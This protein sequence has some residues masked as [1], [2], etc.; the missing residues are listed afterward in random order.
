MP[1]SSDAGGRP[2]VVVADDSAL[3]RRVLADVL[4]GG[5]RDNGEFRVVATA[6]DGLDAIRK[7]HQHKP[8]VVT[9][10]L[11]MPQLD[12]L[13]AIGY[14]MSEA[15]RPIVVVSAHAGP[16][17]Q[18]AIRA[19]ELGAVEIVAKPPPEVF[20]QPSAAPE[21]LAPQLIAA[22]PRVVA[23]AAYAAPGVF[24][25]QVGSAAAG[26]VIALDQSAPLW[27]VRPTADPLFRSIAEVYAARAVGV[28]LTGL[29]RDGASG[30]R[31]MRDAGATRLA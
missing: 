2:T 17:T 6:R 20:G 22:V 28:V 19:L 12:G 13:G 10:D 25:M 29:G 16:G 21:S 5:D 11:E 30:L 23:A 3:M 9:L 27:G 24:D 14:I 8:D 1:T 15:P 7:V 4:G 26:P 31:T 18:A